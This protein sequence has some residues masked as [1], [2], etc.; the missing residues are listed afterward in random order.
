MYIYPIHFSDILTPFSYSDEFEING[1]NLTFNTISLSTSNSNDIKFDEIIMKGDSSIET[2]SDKSEKTLIIEEI[3]V[4]EN[5]LAKIINAQID[6]EISLEPGSSLTEDFNLA[7]GFSEIEL[8]WDLDQSPLFNPLN[9]QKVIPEKIE[10]V[11]KGASTEGR[12]QLFHDFLSKGVILMRNIKSCSEIIPKIHFKSE[13]ANEFNDGESLS[14]KC[15]CINNNELQLISDQ[16][17]VP[18]ASPFPTE[19]PYQNGTEPTVDFTSFNLAGESIQF[20]KDGYRED[21]KDY[22]GNDNKNDILLVNAL[23]T[24]LTTSTTNEQPNND[25]YL[26]PKA[27]NSQITIPSSN[28]YGQGEIGIHANSNNPTITIPKSKVPLKLFNNEN[29][30]INIILNGEK[31][32]SISLNRLLI[33]KGVIKFN[34][35]NGVTG[36]H[37]DKVEVYNTGNIQSLIGENKA[38]TEIDNLDM[39]SGSTVTMSNAK[40]SQTVKSAPHS[41]LIIN[42]K[43]TF[44]ENTNIQLTETSLIEFGNSIIEGVCKEIKLIETGT[45]K[46]S[47]HFNSESEVQLACGSRF[48]CFSWLSKYSGNSK[49]PTAKCINYTNSNEMCLVARSKSNQENN[50]NPHHKKKLSGGA[51]AGICIACVVVTAVII[52]LVLYCLKRHHDNKILQYTNMDNAEFNDPSHL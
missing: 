25:F 19:V 46:E 21:G 35:P 47:K 10:I 40:F 23:S 42:G 14:I 12:E 16:K 8:E 20:T 18:A 38:D 41:K 34:I 2:V 45:S 48:E 3:K 24:K 27:K 6:D 11:Y 52:G 33:N 43:S 32:T 28:D 50:V 9:I 7:E 15:Q 4:K 1:K 13:S 29:S 36:L 26:S 31:S 5:S 22:S 44:N 17:E 39:K 51:I 30:E 37:F 49:Y